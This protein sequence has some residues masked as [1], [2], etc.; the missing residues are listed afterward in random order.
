MS[1]RLRITILGCGSSGGVPRLGGQWGVCDPNNPKNRRSRCAALVERVAPGGTTRVLIDAG[2]DCREQLL[3]ADVGLLDGVL[4]THDHADHCHGID[5]LRVITFNRQHRLPIWADARTQS[6]LNAR[7]GYVFEQPPGS[8]YP[9]ILAAN[10]IGAEEIEVSGA[11]GPLVFEPIPVAHGGITALGFRVADVAYVPDVS[12]ISKASTRRLMGL[13]L[14]ILDALRRD[15]H[16]THFHLAR[17]LE[18][19][20][21]LTPDQAILTNLHNDLDYATLC[22]ELP[23]HIRPAYDGLVLDLPLEV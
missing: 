15:P 22:A 21:K 14:W 12:G 23:A 1:D 11:G 5:D 17:S 3:R 13:R 19:I 8:P 20:E 7:F 10:R 4:F 9:P 18:W 2:P 6:V 16:P